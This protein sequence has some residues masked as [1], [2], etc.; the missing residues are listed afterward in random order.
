MLFSKIL[1]HIE[2]SQL[3]YYANQLTGFYMA[4]VFT[5]SYF[6]IDYTKFRKL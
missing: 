6:Q 5:E 3:I 2:T 4:R 1:Y